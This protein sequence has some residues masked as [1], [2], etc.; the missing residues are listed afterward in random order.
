MSAPA[1][2]RLTMNSHRTAFH[3][4]TSRVCLEY[5]R[6]EISFGLYVM[7]FYEKLMVNSFAIVVLSLLIWELLC[8]FPFYCIRS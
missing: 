6:Y 4:L 3:Q 1:V 8:Y 5:Y 2:T 7:T